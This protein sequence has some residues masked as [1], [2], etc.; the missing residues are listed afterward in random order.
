[1][2][3]RLFKYMGNWKILFM[4]YGVKKF[5]CSGGCFVSFFDIKCVV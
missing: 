2:M 5:L 4:L 1:M 3:N